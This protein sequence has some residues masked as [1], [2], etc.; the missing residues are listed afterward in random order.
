[1]QEKEKKKEKTILYEMSNEQRKVY[2]HIKEGKNVVVDACA[3]SGK[4]TTI[5]SIAKELPKKQFLQTTYNSML[6]KEIK[7]KI[8]DLQLE[9]LSVQTFHSLCVKY[10]LLSAYTDTGIRYVI[11]NNTPP[12]LKIPP[13]DILVIDEAQDMTFLYY[14]FMV[15]YIRDSG[16]Q[17]IQLLILGDYMQGLYEFKGADT[18]FLTHA[19]K[20]WE[21]L[22]QLKTP[23]FEKCTLKMSYRITQPMADF[24]NNVMLGETRLLACKEGEPINYIRNSRTFIEKIVI[25]E[26]MKILENGGN[27][28]DIFVLNESVKGTS[29]N[30]RKM[31]N[32]LVEKDIPCHV[33]LI[34]NE[35]IDEKVIEGKVVFSTF[36][37]VKGRQRKYV[38]VSGFDNYYMSKFGRDKGDNQCP[39]T[40]YVATTRAT[41][42]LYLLENEQYGTDRP[43]CFL[44][45]N[46][47]EMKNQPY[48]KFKGQPRSIFY[49]KNEG[50]EKNKQVWPP[51][52]D[53][54]PTNLVSYMKESVIEEIS[55]ILDKIFQKIS[56]EEE[57][58]WI[59]IPVLLKTKR[60]FYEDISD[61]NGIA[62]PCYYNDYLMNEWEKKEGEKK[63]GEKKEEEKKEGETKNE[64]I[65]YETIRMSLSETRPQDYA[66]LKKIIAEELPDKCTRISDYLYLANIH[67]AVQERLYFK[68]KQ[69]DRDE[70][71][72]LSD[73]IMEKCLDRMNTVVGRDEKTFPQI[74]KMMINHT[75]ES[76]NETLNSILA[77]FFKEKGDIFR[78]SA[79]TDLITEDTVWEFKCTTMIT[80]EHK[81]QVII[82]AWIWK[83]IFPEDKKDFKLL[84]I[85]SGEIIKLDATKEEMTEIIVLLLKGKYGNQEKKKDEEFIEDCR[86]Y[87][88]VENK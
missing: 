58:D 7:I 33:P 44:K 83:H 34:E 14:Q 11:C 78:F 19:D 12:R 81:L 57:K 6:K 1:M 75:M 35:N 84:N 73:E 68:I 17:N 41:D 26:I 43:L 71:E 32:V 77:P 49:K 46:H 74:E 76:E 86:K 30:I 87:I 5:L 59:D 31:E 25:Y 23:C 47:Y 66:Y 2:D 62:I 42:G 40:L 56:T 88:E 9:N 51:K 65:L 69:I 50:V 10:Y 15:K 13:L 53:I 28:G 37:S 55:P 60:G 54:T 63:E 18:R 4:S 29:S 70:Y 39:N 16:F 67:V 79:R 36:H 20:I 48:I 80:I 8:D 24:V 38:F 64:N 45:M 82:Y 3:G 52:H 21:K 72:W 85:K 22:V 27:P 61:L